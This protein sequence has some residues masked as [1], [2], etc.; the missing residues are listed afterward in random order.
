MRL[1]SRPDG[2]HAYVTNYDDGT[3]SVITTATGKVAAP[4]KVGANPHAVAVAPDGKHAYVT[5]SGDGTVSVISTATGTGGGS[6]H[7]R[8]ESIRTG[9]DS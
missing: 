5:N 2:K 4:I 1:R 6:D 9:D 3:V 7:C 8:P